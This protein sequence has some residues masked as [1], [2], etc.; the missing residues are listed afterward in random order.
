MH[1]HSCNCWAQYC[2]ALRCWCG[3]FP[4]SNELESEKEYANS[5]NNNDIDV[6]YTYLAVEMSIDIIGRRYSCFF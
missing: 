2:T 6:P 1:V 4:V 5:V 3:V